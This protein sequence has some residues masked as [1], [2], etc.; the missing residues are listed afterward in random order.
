MSTETSQ[1]KGILSPRRAELHTFPLFHIKPSDV[2]LH[3][4]LRELCLSREN[5]PDVETVYAINCKEMSHVQEIVDRFLHESYDEKI[6]R[7]KRTMSIF[8]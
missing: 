2:H 6:I 5:L 1:D 8:S 7:V 4:H 3:T